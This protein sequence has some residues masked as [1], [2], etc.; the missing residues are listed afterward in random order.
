MIVRFLLL[1]IL[2]TAQLVF[3]QADRPTL[4]QKLEAQWQLYAKA[5]A[6]LLQ[7]VQNPN[8]SV[9]QKIISRQQWENL[10]TLKDQW[11]LTDQDIVAL[12]RSQRLRIQQA[13]LVNRQNSSIDLNQV[14]QKKTAQDFC[15]Q[16]PKGGMLH[17][18]PSGT[19]DKAT[20]DSLLQSLNPNLDIES[21]LQSIDSSEGNVTLYPQERTWLLSIP[22]NTNYLSLAP[23]DRKQFESFLFLPQ[24]KQPF[25]RFN[26][27]FEFIGF[28]IPDW[29]SYEKVLLNFA[30]KAVREGVSYVEFT[31]G[32]NADLFDH[33]ANVEQKT[34]LVIRVNKS[35]NR[36]KDPVTINE[37]LEKLL[38]AQPSPYLLGIDF[39]DNEEGNPAF[40]KGQLLYGSVLSA[41][42][43]GKSNL[44]RTMHAG[45]IGDIR[46]ARDAMILG[47]ERLGHGVNLAKD[48]VALE[49]AAKIHE[50][51][52]VNLSSNLR[53]TDVKSISTHPFLD[54][55]RL[56][57]PVSLSTDDE[58][59]FE[60][61][62]NHECE[63]A[64]DETDISY[65]EMKQMAFN[66]IE[67][68]FASDTDKKILLQKLK[69]QFKIFE[70]TYNKT[71]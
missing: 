44:H 51:V 36:T 8:L 47:A 6:F 2:A 46:N 3:A 13:K 25:S 9:S 10:L 42:V 18:H 52:E 45:E 58:G 27:V 40:E 62:I 60:I 38:S 43:L 17:I 22:Q 65:A 59:I 63:I 53:L 4:Q 41:N 19:L 70:K 48:P 68:S 23:N 57:L 55:L 69:Q 20:A 24:G 11:S 54:Y 16:I 49:Y 28:A 71:H 29:N 1:S 31:T 64:I 12:V 34:G 32:A 67:T 37:A 7:Q 33:I 39:L 26:S 14:R 66:S 50:P 21:V 30:Q 56:G 35:F 15:A 61:D 5:Q